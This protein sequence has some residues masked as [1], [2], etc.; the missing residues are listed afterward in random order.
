MADDEFELVDEDED[1]ATLELDADDLED[2][3]DVTVEIDGDDDEDGGHTTAMLDDDDE[4]GDDEEEDEDFQDE[5]LEEE[6]ARPKSTGYTVMLGL[7]TVFW[8]ASIV[9]VMYWLYEYCDRDQFLWGM[10]A[11]EK[12]GP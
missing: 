10:V 4:V 2:G 5:A 11:E 3:D 9:V 1:G 8:I 6:F 12:A 7:T